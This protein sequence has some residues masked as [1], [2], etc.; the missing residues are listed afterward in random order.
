LILI[1]VRLI[2]LLVFFQLL[3]CLPVQADEL[4]EYDPGWYAKINYTIPAG[5]SWACP[6]ER[7]HTDCV[8]E[9]FFW[10]AENRE[11]LL[12]I[13]GWDVGLTVRVISQSPNLCL[14]GLFDSRKG[15]LWDYEAF[16]SWRGGNILNSCAILEKKPCEVEGFVTCIASKFSRKFPFD[17][18]S[19]LP[20]T[21]ITCPL[22]NFFGSRFDLCF[23]YEAMRLMKYPIAAALVIKFFLYL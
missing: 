8:P 3:F 17:I 18:I 2:A 7:S 23:I 16:R 4:E 20:S 21:Q 13:S 11:D 9:E 12:F 1:L 22:V 6:P 14:V 10:D 15:K 5:S 19:N